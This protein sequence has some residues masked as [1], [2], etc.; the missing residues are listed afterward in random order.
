MYAS[1]KRSMI[2]RNLY[3]WSLT[4]VPCMCVE[5]VYVYVCVCHWHVYV[6]V[7]FMHL[8]CWLIH[9]QELGCAIDSNACH[10]SSVQH[11]RFTFPSEHSKTPMFSHPKCRELNQPLGNAIF[12]P[13][14]GLYCFHCWQKHEI[15]RLGEARMIHLSKI[16]SNASVFTPEIW[17]NQST[18]RHSNRFSPFDL[19]ILPF[20]DKKTWDFEIQGG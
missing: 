7:C 14:L 19:C 9:S 11:H 6:C 10:A 20:A 12:F 2:P 5:Q 1:P 15:L 8:P 18:S 17:W 16:P 4:I 3:H 13:H